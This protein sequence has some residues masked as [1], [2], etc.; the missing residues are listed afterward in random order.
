MRLG[1][2]VKVKEGGE[3]GRVHGICHDERTGAWEFL[4]NFGEDDGIW[5]NKIAVE[6]I[7]HE[8]F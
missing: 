6:E 4:V 1:S 3:T 2:I 5:F 8:P 7:G